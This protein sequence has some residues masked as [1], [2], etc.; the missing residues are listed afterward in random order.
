M[1]ILVESYAKLNPGEIIYHNL[2]GK[3]INLIIE[4]Q[5]LE[6]SDA[7]NSVQLTWNKKKYQV[8][9]KPI[10][11]NNSPIFM[12]W[13]QEGEGYLLKNGAFILKG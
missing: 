2:G 13:I 6:I 7:Q 10:E 8:L 3:T 12:P 4:N 1:K 9:F 11:T 5:I